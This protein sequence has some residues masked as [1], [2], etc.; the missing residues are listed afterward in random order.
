MRTTTESIRRSIPLAR[1][2]IGPRELELVSQVLSGD[3]L[4]M[5][6]FTE[7]F[8]R[9]IAQLAERRH[10]IACS[11]GTAGLH[12]GVRAL[13][14]GEGDEVITTPFSF[15]ASANC[16]LYERAVPR[17]VD[18]EEDSLGID[19]DLVDAAVTTRTKGILP[20]HVFGKPCRIDPIMATARR[21]GWSVI[22]DSCEALGTSLN[23]RPL[24]SYGDVSVFAFY[25]NKQVTTGE[26]GIALA[27]DP[28]VAETMASLRN[29]G[30]DS[31]GT[32]LRHVRLG[33][34]YRIDEMSAA[35][36]V[37]QLER[38]TELKAGRD[39][40]ARAYEQAFAGRD[41]VRLPQ[42]GP[43]EEIDWFVYV[44]RLAPDIDRDALIGLLAAR[45]VPSRPYFAPIHLQPFYREAF[46]YKPGDFP[47]T[48]RVA[49]STLAVPFSSRLSEDDVAYVANELIAA[50]ERH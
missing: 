11:S 8:E 41:W 48:E 28:L 43:G 1:P 24:G 13:G 19:P 12:M 44:L 49:A 46:G 10:A 21:R 6:P 30:R 32:W 26:G 39:R 18:I 3:S 16:L 4:A 42:A 5:G 2:D 35:V 33:Y 47:V 25:P 34:N 14:I 15:V 7:Q 50:V 23:G 22:E 27:D 17:F 36:G 29:Q 40:A 9:G 20:V 45:G 38:R 37:A 31:D